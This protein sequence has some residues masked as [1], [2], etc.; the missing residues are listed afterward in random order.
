MNESTITVGCLMAEV[1]ALDSGEITSVT[2]DDVKLTYCPTSESKI[3][4][5]IV[6]PQM[7]ELG[8][9][10][11]LPIAIARAHLDDLSQF[12]LFAVNGLSADLRFAIAHKGSDFVSSAL[13][14]LAFGQDVSTTPD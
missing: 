13:K 14:G 8:K 12:S 6:T 3:E 2:V 9:V 1:F 7:R 11:F 10:G 5:L 4:T